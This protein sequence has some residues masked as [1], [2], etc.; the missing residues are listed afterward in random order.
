MPKGRFIV[1]EGLD[2]S[3]ISTQTEYLRTWFQ[4]SRIP[5]SVT[6]E[7]TDGPAGAIAKWALR[8]ELRDVPEH[9]LALLFAADRQYHVE[10][11]IIPSLGAGTN[12]ICDRYF[13]SSFAY[14]LVKVNDLDWLRK[15]NAKC[16][17]PDLT[18]FLD[19]PVED[20]LKRMTSDAWRGLDKLQLYEDEQQLSQIRENFLTVISSLQTEGH[21]IVIVD[22]GDEIQ[23]VGERIVDCTK[24]LLGPKG[25]TGSGAYHSGSHQVAAMLEGKPLSG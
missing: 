23:Q 19:I 4:R 18:I 16:P 17:V 6:K 20:C 2:G 1:L 15:L 14:Q 8:K 10:R 11:E 25:G 21:N 3:G 5:V 9:A 13:L 12:V 24:R 22:A 7:P